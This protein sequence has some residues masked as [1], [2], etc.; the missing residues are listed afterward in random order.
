SPTR[1]RRQWYHLIL[2]EAQ[3]IKNFKSQRWQTLLTFN[4]QRR[5]LLTGTPL[6]NSLMELWSLMHF[7]MP[8]VFRSRKEFSYWF[9]QPLTHMVEGSRERNDDLIRRLHSVV[10]PFLLRRLKKDVEKQLPGKYEHVV[11]CR[12]S[13]RQASLYEEFMARSSTRAALQGGNFMGM[14]NILM[15]LRKVCNHP[16]LF[17]ARQIDSPLVLPPLEIGLG[18]RVLRNR[19]PSS[20]P[21]SGFPAVFGGVSYDQKRTG[22]GEGG[23]AALAVSGAGLAESGGAVARGVFARIGGGVSTSLI[24]PLWAHDVK[25]GLPGLDVLSTELLSRRATPAE[26]VL[27]MPSKLPLPVPDP[28]QVKTKVN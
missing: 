9:S 1:R 20:L 2:D 10:R 14:M 7:L 6:Q 19:P 12:L 11:M 25:D 23:V 28:A 24:A 5:L 8:H 17:E 4:S 15:Q 27:K 3:N 13:R 22:S 16:D 26:D 18:T 21:P